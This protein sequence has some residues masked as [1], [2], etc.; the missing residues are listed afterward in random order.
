MQHE[1]KKQTNA[2]PKNG[3]IKDQ[4]KKKAISKNQIK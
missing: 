3:Q 2:V 1:D 4:P